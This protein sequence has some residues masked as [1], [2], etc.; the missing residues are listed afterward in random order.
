MRPRLQGLLELLSIGALSVALCLF[1]LNGLGIGRGASG[2]TPPTG[3]PIGQSAPTGVHWGAVAAT[4]LAFGEASTGGKTT[5]CSSPYGKGLVCLTATPS[6]TFDRFGRWTNISSDVSGSPGGRLTT[7]AWDGS[8]GYGLL[9]GGVKYGQVYLNDTWTYANGT[10]TNITA[11]VGSSPP[12][13]IYERMAYD[14]SSNAV[15]L[16]GGQNKTMQVQHQ[17]WTYHAGK[18]TNLTGGLPSAPSGRTNF[19]FVTDSA[20]GEALLSGGGPFSVLGDTWTFHHDAWTNISSS[21]P[22]GAIML[23]PVLA[24]DPPDHGVLMAGPFLFGPNHEYPGTFLFY[25]G[26]WHNRTTPYSTQPPMFASAA[27]GYVPGAAGVFLHGEALSNTTGAYGVYNSTWEFAGGVWTDVT[28]WTGQQPN[29]GE[30][31]G[32]AVDPVDGTMIL[33]GGLSLYASPLLPPYTWVLNVPPTATV[34]ASR[35]V[36]DAGLGVTFTG[37]VSSGVSPN[38]PKWSF[39]DGGTGSTMTVSHTYRDSGLYAATLTETSLTGTNGSASVYVY[40]NPSLG[41]TATGTTNV[42]E[43]ELDSFGAS[44][45]GGTAPFAYAWKFGDGA[46]SGIPNPTHAFTTS[47][48]YSVTATVTD[49]LGASTNGTVHIVVLPKTSAPSTNAN[50]VSGIDLVLVTVIVVLLAVSAV[51]GELWLRKPKPPQGVLPQ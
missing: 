33:F 26:T 30:T 48:T 44:V 6:N 19:G 11:S 2:L 25:N 8:D 10:W 39:G 46:T 17:T 36:V 1:G 43:N 22:V 5:G 15:V 23:T 35:S 27:L 50:S 37:G 9:F 31:R 42:S 14:P 49:S 20:D 21:A 34:S 24:D 47:G 28:N 41:V 3:P 29:S 51:L 45:T 4:S 40:V 18:W 32:Y 38:V 7:M 12:A 13:L 16:F